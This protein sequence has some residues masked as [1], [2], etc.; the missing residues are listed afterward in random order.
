MGRRIADAVRTAG[1]G[2]FERVAIVG[3]TNAYQSYT[4][5]PEEYDACAYEGSFTL[6]GRRQGPRLRDV[7]VSLTQALTGGE[8]PPS[9]EPP[10]SSIPAEEPASP[11]DATPDAGTVVDEPVALVTPPGAGDLHLEGRQPRA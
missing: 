5:T 11:P 4:S 1:G 9:A 3:L 8:L 10:N 2:T 6:W 7:A